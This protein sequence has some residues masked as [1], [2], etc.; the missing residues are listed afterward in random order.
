MKLNAFI[1]AGGKSS[2]MG[3]DKGLVHLSGKPM[4]QYIIDILEQLKL[5]IQIVS[6]NS[7]YKHFGYP[8]FKDL[9]SDKGP[10]GGIYTALSSSDSEMNLILSCDTPFVNSALIECLIAECENQNV[11]IS[12]YEG[13]QHPLIGIY[14]KSGIK[15]FQSQIEK[16]NLKLSEANEILHVKA[17]PMDNIK[18]ITARAFDN[19]NTIEELKEAGN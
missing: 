10:I 12:G 9:I 8:V 1:L 3:V 14:S 11:T 7:E 17:V 2:R 18:G 19:I 15:T 16:D 6:N 4:I 5:P 13:W